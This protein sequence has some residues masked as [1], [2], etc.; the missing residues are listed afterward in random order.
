MPSASNSSWQTTR[1]LVN[2]FGIREGKK[3]HQTFACMCCNIENICSTGNKHR[4]STE[5]DPKAP[6][7]MEVL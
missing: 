5:K 7:E 6:Q 4:E 2:V 1:C 3:G